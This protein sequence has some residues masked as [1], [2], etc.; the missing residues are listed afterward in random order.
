MSR[1]TRE[2][3]ALI[4]HKPAAGR[5]WWWWSRI[6]PWSACAPLKTDE[7]AEIVEL[8]AATS[9]EHVVGLWLQHVS[10]LTGD[11][12]RVLRA[13]G[14]ALPVVPRLNLSDE[15]VLFVLN[16]WRDGAGKAEDW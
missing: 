3:Q 14:S 4:A 16:G 13:L 1:L 12:L 10:V 9:T 8:A 15:V 11:E 6:L 7:L 5:R 2:E